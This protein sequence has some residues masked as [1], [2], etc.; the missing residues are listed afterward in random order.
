MTRLF[1]F[2]ERLMLRGR[3]LKLALIGD[4]VEHSAS[5][6]CSASFSK[7]RASMASYVAIRVARG[8]GAGDSA[9]ARGGL[10]GCNVTIR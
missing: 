3:R 7:R 1:R 8:D 6:R 2:F 5:P 10:L 4:P 9:N